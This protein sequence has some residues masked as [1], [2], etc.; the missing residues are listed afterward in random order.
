MTIRVIEGAF[1]SAQT[2][3]VLKDVGKD[4]NNIVVQFTEGSHGAVLVEES[5]DEGVT[6]IESKRFNKT[7]VGAFMNTE[8]SAWFRFNCIQI[9]GT[10]YCRMSSS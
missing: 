4:W 10:V 6:W 7:G 5:Y 9:S 1:V 2:S 3:D 8:A